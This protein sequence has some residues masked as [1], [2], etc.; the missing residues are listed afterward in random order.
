M[1][2]HDH[3]RK[4]FCARRGGSN[5]GFHCNKRRSEQ[6]NENRISVE[7]P[8]ST[9]RSGIK[10]ADPSNN[11]SR[12]KKREKSRKCDTGAWRVL[13]ATSEVLPPT[14]PII[15]NAP[16]SLSPVPFPSRAA[17]SLFAGAHLTR[18]PR[19]VLFG[20]DWHSCG[21]GP[22]AP[23]LGKASRPQYLWV[24][25]GAFVPRKRGRTLSPVLR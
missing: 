14:S 13:P 19:N 4:V 22:A 2:R 15:P 17:P 9:R 7:K 3:T 18:C 11:G 10:S 8:M 23:C 16:I 12:E 5:R 1:C 20:F 21:L 6:T 25:T 24:Q